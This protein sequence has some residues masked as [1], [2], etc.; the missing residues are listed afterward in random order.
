[1]SVAWTICS[2]SDI[3]FG[4][5]QLAVE[6]DLRTDLR[7]LDVGAGKVLAMRSWRSLVSMV[8]RT[9]IERVLPASS[10]SVRVVFPK[11]SP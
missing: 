9:V 2:T 7:D 1:M 10:Q 6:D 11:E 5:G 3:V 8:T 4:V